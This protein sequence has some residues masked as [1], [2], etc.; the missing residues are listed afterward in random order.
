MG[1]VRAHHASVLLKNGKVLVAGGSVDLSANGWPVGT[2]SS[3]LYD[4]ET[5]TWT[6]TGSMNSDRMVPALLLPN[7]K[8]L[9][10]GNGGGGDSGSSS[11]E[12][13]D[14]DSGSWAF[15]GSMTYARK[16]H[17][18]ALLSGG[19]VLA[20]G[21]YAVPAGGGMTDESMAATTEIYD[22]AT[23]EWTFTGSMNTP[24]V[25]PTATVLSSGKVLV[26]GGV[27]WSA[28]TKP[29]E[30]LDSA[31][32]YDPTTGTWSDA[33]S[34]NT[35]RAAHTAILLPDGKVLIAGGAK[36]SIGSTPTTPSTTFQVV[37]HLSSAEIFN[38][39]SGTWT[40]VENMS[41]PRSGHTA[42]L[43]CDGTVLVI[44]GSEEV[45]ELASVEIFDP[46]TGLWTQTD[47]M[48]TPSSGHGATLLP[49]GNVLISGGNE[50]VDCG[51][52]CSSY[53]PLFRAEIFH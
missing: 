39:S 42:T 16:D 28:P 8:V 17:A 47:D 34:M 23:G 26:T 12:L 14:P 22:P 32:I 21:G 7:G 29:Y 6:P 24:R 33:G 31:E 27:T 49:N 9:V 18:I 43:L 3:E 35:D 15:T 2:N 52:V 10:V 50:S 44:G 4:P 38:P 19:K 51:G 5:G 13:Y 37:N 30:S 36:F 41:V 1:T 53:P 40:A 45:A 25:R 11:A 48:A 46:A 20:I